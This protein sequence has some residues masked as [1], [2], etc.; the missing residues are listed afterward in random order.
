MSKIIVVG[1]S[2]TIGRAV[3]DL[4]GQ[5]H[6]VIRIGNRQGDYMVDLSSKASIENVFES[7]GSIDAAICAAG[8]SRFG[9][10]GEASD[11]DFMFSINNKLMGQVNLVRIAQQ[12]VS[13]NGSITVTTGLLAREPWPGTV[14]TAM[15]NAALEGFVR[16]AALDASNGIRI[17]AVSPIFVTETATKMGMDKAGTMS[18]TET[19]KAYQSC[20]TGNMTGQVLDVRDY[21]KVE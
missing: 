11:D 12:H 6:Q 13:A 16:A 14:P 19:A 21:G 15:V 9:K 5:T 20:I 1:A 7:I 8:L 10:L 2:G 17:N 3:A 18:A 4:L